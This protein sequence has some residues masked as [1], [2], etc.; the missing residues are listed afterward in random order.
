MG[1]KMGAAFHLLDQ[2]MVRASDA[3]NRRKAWKCETAGCPARVHVVKEHRRETDSGPH[4]IPPFFRLNPGEQH[5][6]LC[7]YNLPGY[8]QQIYAQSDSDVLQA[9]AQGIYA[10]RLHL[11]DGPLRALGSSTGRGGAGSTGAPQPGRVLDPYLRVLSQILELRSAIYSQPNLARLIQLRFGQ[12]VIRWDDFYYEI[13]D[14]FSAHQ[15]LT[16]QAVKSPPIC[17]EGV[18]KRVQ[19]PSGS[20]RD[21]EIYLA[22]IRRTH[23]DAPPEVAAPRA[24]VRTPDLVLPAHGERVLVFGRWHSEPP[25]PGATRFLRLAVDLY[26]PGQLLVVP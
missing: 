11:L 25:Q 21:P 7:R 26:R 24:R 20:I 19:Q 15:H 12:S 18:V 22:G 16:S 8:V 5:T 3:A 10:F 17:I 2:E 14:Y 13:G 23:G 4:T 1:I 6:T 9:L